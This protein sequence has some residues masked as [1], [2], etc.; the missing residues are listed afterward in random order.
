MQTYIGVIQIGRK[1][2]EDLGRP[3]RPSGKATAGK[4]AAW[5]KVSEIVVSKLPTSQAHLWA[6]RQMQDVARCITAPDEVWQSLDALFSAL[7]FGSQRPLPG[8]PVM[9]RKLY[10]DLSG[11][12]N[13]LTETGDIYR[14]IFRESLRLM[15][16]MSVKYMCDLFLGDLFF[17][18]VLRAGK[19]LAITK[20]RKTMEEDEEEDSDEAETKL[21]KFEELDRHFSPHTNAGAYVQ[22]RATFQ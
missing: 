5:E 17:N 9:T 6:K 18:N 10:L 11:A 21:Y 8:F 16:L 14:R 7:E 22:R 1:A 4:F 3:P 19:K 2:L 15:P 20:K 12:K 13:I